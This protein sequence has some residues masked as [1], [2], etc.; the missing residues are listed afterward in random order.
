MMRRAPAE[1]KAGS[2]VE[3]ADPAVEDLVGDFHR[4]DGDDDRV[5]KKAPATVTPI[6]M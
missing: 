4:D 6:A 2:A 3:R 1:Q 5:A